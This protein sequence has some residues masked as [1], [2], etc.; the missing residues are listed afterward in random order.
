MAFLAFWAWALVG[1]LAAAAL[2]QDSNLSTLYPPLWDES[3]EQFSDYRVENGKYIIDPWVFTDRMGMY[4][5][6]LNQTAKYFAKFAPENEQNILWGLP[7]QHGWQYRSGRLADPTRRTDCGY[8]PGDTLCISVDSWWADINYYLSVPPFLAAIDSGILN[9]SST[10]I[11][12]LPPPED[13]AKFCYDVSG[14][15]SF[16]PEIMDGWRAFFQYMQSPSSDFEGLLKYLWDAHTSSLDYPVSVFVDRYA[17]YF[18]PEADF[19]KN[20]A[21]AVNYLAASRLPTTLNRTHN[22]QAGFPPRV[23]VDGDIAPFIGD[24]TPLQNRVLLLLQVL[25]VTHR[26]TGSLSLVAWKIAMSTKAARELFL[27]VLEYFL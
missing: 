21:V 7:L 5:I 4:R 16:V 2:A 12:I 3:P 17:Y 13:E 14:C 18:E 22:F 9:I 1:C 6:L 11:K 20:W 10:Q 19:E 23:L 15:Q 26:L 24:F 8:Y 25:G 27:K